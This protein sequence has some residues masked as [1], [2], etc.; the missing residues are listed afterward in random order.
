MQPGSQIATPVSN[1]TQSMCRGR[2]THAGGRARP[3]W[4]VVFG[5]GVLVTTLL[6]GGCAT[7]RAKMVADGPPLEVP[8][9]PPRVITA[10]DEPLP[11][12]AAEE[13]P[14]A[15]PVSPT[16]T[17]PIRPVPRAEVKPEAPIEVVLPDGN[18]HATWIDTTTGAVVKQERVTGGGTR[19]VMSPTY[20][21]DIALRLTAGIPNPENNVK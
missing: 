8:E 9:P 11:A 4:D 18:W 14:A 1:R 3:H 19:T 17:P 6:G 7:A 13:S 2:R 10:I 16:P 20:D 12:T 15:A 21:D 5:I